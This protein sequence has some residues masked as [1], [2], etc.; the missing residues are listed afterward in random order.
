M[1]GGVSY[2]L[3][4]GLSNCLKQMLTSS[5]VKDVGFQH[6]HPGVMYACARETPTLWLFRLA[7]PMLMMS[8][9]GQLVD[10]TLD[11]LD[12]YDFQV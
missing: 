12:V 9:L 5:A 11:D 7:L 1:R 10:L 6:M 8:A 3:S 4:L 2:G